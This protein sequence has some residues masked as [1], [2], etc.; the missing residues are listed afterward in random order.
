MSRVKEETSYA[1]VI[2][3]LVGSRAVAD[4]QALHQA[5]NTVLG[6]VNE[7][8]RPRQ[9]FRVTV[10]DEFQGVCDDL[11]QALGATLV[12]R[13]RMAASADVR[14]GIGW[15]H[16][17]ALDERVQDGPGWWAARAAIEQAKAAEARPAIRTVRTFV[18][19][20]PESSA[21]VAAAVPGLNAA[22]MARDH[23]V[24]MLSER[25]MRLLAGM[26]AGRTQQELAE[27]E[28]ISASAVSQRVRHD[29]LGV[30]LAM[31]ELWTDQERKLPR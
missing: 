26:L 1:T 20:A 5:L 2:G 13:V 3:D 24:G 9:P 6:Q 15:G 17:Q 12:I 14:H 23:L 18:R 28:G 8:I 4:R 31:Q 19:A 7:E 21:A 11:G 22:L 25:S 27:S 10:G 29:G 16:I 30:L